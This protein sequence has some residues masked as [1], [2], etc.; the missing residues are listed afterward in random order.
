MNQ[1]IEALLSGIITF[2]LT[3]SYINFVKVLQ[4]S[5]QVQTKISDLETIV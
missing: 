4:E 1:Q 3:G 5:K 2:T